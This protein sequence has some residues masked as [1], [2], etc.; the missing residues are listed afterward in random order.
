[1]IMNLKVSNHLIFRFSYLFVIKEPPHIVA[2]IAM[3]QGS[4][5][6]VEKRKG[7]P[8]KYITDVSMCHPLTSLIYA[9]HAYYQG[10]FKC[11]PVPPP[12]GVCHEF[13]DEASLELRPREDLR[14]ISA[15]RTI[16][17]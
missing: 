17:L 16:R 12:I 15:L 7:R 11:P 6:R 2:E 8:P 1:M 10:R 3:D 5:E 13:C 4:S 14:R 9:Y